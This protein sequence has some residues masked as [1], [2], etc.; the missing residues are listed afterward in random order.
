MLVVNAGTSSGIHRVDDD[1]HI[2]TQHVAVLGQQRRQRR[3]ATSSSLST[4]GTTP[5]GG[6][7]AND[8]GLVV[9]HAAAE[10]PSIALGWLERRRRPLCSDWPAARRG[11][12]KAAQLERARGGP[13]HDHRWRIAG[14]HNPDLGG[15]R[16]AGHLGHPARSTINF[17]LSRRVSGDGGMPT[18]SSRSF[19][20][21]GRIPSI[22][23]RRSSGPRRDVMAIHLSSARCPRTM[24]DDTDSGSPP[25][26]CLG[27]ASQ[28]QL[29]AVMAS[30]ESE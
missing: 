8:P 5:A 16:G 11:A 2:A 12:R 3:R 13:R 22:A 23:K 9:G 26:P 18:S 28:G 7:P 27:R 21:H 1:D 24:T 29:E 10:Q 17:C 15:A 25:L 6:R 30:D 14:R 4:K 19:R 20:A